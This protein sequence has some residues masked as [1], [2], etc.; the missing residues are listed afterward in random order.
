MMAKELIFGTT[1]TIVGLR[2]ALIGPDGHV[3][4]VL[5]GVGNATTVI[6][7]SPAMG[8]AFTQFLVT[9]DTG[10]G[11]FFRADDF[12][13]FVFVLNG[14]LEGGVPGQLQSLSA[15][16]YAF[17]P[18]GQSLELKEATAGTRATFFVKKYVPL[19]GEPEPSFS[20]GKSGTCRPSPSSAMKRPACRFCCLT[21]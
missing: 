6:L 12:E 10:G 4:R 2:H 5:P 1:R 18:A 21:P 16:S 9:F 14:E 13:R 7:I 3:P 15:G 8:A 17:V 20:I 11:V 19:A